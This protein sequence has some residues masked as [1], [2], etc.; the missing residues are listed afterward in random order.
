MTLLTA[1]A[2]LALLGFGLL[3]WSCLVVAAEQDRPRARAAGSGI[4]SPPDPPPVQ[5]ADPGS[6]VGR[7]AAPGAAPPG[8]PMPTH[9]SSGRA[10]HIH[11]LR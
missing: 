4:P 10:E 3:L 9:V 7:P 2:G 5:P 11:S 1:A 8:R 6:E